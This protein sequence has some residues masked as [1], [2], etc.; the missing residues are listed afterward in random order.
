VSSKTVVSPVVYGKYPPTRFAE[1]ADVLYHSPKL[2]PLGI[3]NFKDV[4]KDHVREDVFAE[5][6]YSI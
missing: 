5:N 2:V 1:C 6:E 4:D 3:Y